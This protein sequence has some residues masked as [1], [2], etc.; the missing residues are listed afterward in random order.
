LQREYVSA[1]ANS[2]IADPPTM[3]RSIGVIT[4]RLVASGR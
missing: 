4:A 1:G 2:V 3:T